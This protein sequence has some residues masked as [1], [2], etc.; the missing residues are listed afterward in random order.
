MA[1]GSPNAAAYVNQDALM[2]F[3]PD[4]VALHSFHRADFDP[5]LVAKLHC[6]RLRHDDRLLHC[7]ADQDEHLHILVLDYYRSAFLRPAA[8]KIEFTSQSVKSK[9][10]FNPAFRGVHKQHI[11]H[12]RRH[13]ALERPGL[14][15]R[16]H[17]R[18]PDVAHPQN[19][20]LSCPVFLHFYLK[21]LQAFIKRTK[22]ANSTLFINTHKSPFCNLTFFYLNN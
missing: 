8:Q 11:R 21:L 12:H 9:I 15:L 20:P 16:S 7:F 3:Y 19:K 18:C 13:E 5:H 6:R 17:I 22:I 10:V 4:H 1:G 2:L 14:H